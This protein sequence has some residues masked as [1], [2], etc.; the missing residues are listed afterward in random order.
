MKYAAFLRAVNVGGRNI[1]PMSALRDCLE[2]AGFTGVRTFIQSGNVVFESAGRN[3][4]ELTNRIEQALG[5]ATGAEARVVV[6][7]QSEL[8][9]VLAAAP[10]SWRR[11]T[12]LRRNIAFLRPAVTA[13]EAFK[14]V[15]PRPEVDDVKAGAGVLYMATVMSDLARSGLTKLVGTPVY[16]EM[17]IRTFATCQKMLALMDEPA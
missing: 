7:S 2:Q 13:A 11:R 12:D 3:R 1:L 9:A 17:T 10:V 8:K 4:R 14:A 6:L 16:R 5:K 15:K